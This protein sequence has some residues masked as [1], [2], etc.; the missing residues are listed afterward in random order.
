MQAKLLI[1]FV[2]V[3]AA[4]VSCTEGHSNGE[5]ISQGPMGRKREVRLCF[6]F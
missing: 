1:L 4:V 5:H 6:G 2:L 3:A